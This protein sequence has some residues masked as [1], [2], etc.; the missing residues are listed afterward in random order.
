[1]DLTA[2]CF[3]KVCPDKTRVEYYGICKANA[4]NVIKDVSKRGVNANSPGAPQIEVE[5]HMCKLKMSH[6]EQ[7]ICAFPEA[8]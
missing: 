6:L 4:E 3:L 2:N 5:M 7:K 8:L 1:M